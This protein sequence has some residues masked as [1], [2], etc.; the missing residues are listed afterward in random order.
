[1]MNPIVIIVGAFFIA[2][3]MIL[4]VRIGKKQEDEVRTVDMWGSHVEYRVSHFEKY[5]VWLLVLGI[6]LIVWGSIWV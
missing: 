4:W 1:M 5:G 2:A 3:A 6:L